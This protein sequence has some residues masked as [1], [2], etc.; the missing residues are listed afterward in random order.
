MRPT[1]VLT[2]L[3]ALLPASSGADPSHASVAGQPS[4][5]Y[6]FALD[7]QP[8]SPEVV[9]VAGRDGELAPGDLIAVNG[10]WLALREPG[11]Y[12]FRSA[13]EGVL[14]EEGDG[15]T[16]WVG[17]RVEP[18]YGEGPDFVDGLAPLTPDQVHGL[19]GLRAETWTRSCA[20][21]AGF[22]DASRVHLALGQSATQGRDD[23][24]ELPP[25][26]RSLEASRFVGWG[27]LRTL[28]SLVHLE[29]LPERTFDVR[30]IAGLR[31]LEVLRV[32]HGR[33]VHAEALA[34]LSAL[35][36]LDLRFHHELATLEFARSL[37]RL[38]E[39]VIDGTGVKDLRPLSELL[40][41]ERVQANGSL[42]ERL[43]AGSLPALREL[44]LVAARAP[45]EEIEAFRRTHP[46][47][48]V[49]HGWN[50]S[51]REALRGATRVRV[52]PGQDLAFRGRTPPTYE[53]ADPAE[54]SGLLRLFEVDE[55]QSG[56]VCGCLCGAT[57]EFLAGDEPLETTRL[58]CNHMLRWRA[59]PGDGAL[60][61]ANA[62]ALRDW[63]ADR[64]V[65]GPR[66]EERES[67]A[68]QEA[69]RRKWARATAG[70]SPGLRQALEQEG[71]LAAEGPN[72]ERQ[73]FRAALAV[74]FPVAADRIRALLRVLGA[75]AGSWSGLDG[76]EVVADRLLR[77]YD[78]R[79]LE[80]VCKA[81]L[82]SGD[83]QLRRGAGRFWD[84]W[85][86]PLESWRPGREPAVR[87]ALLDVLQEGQSPDLRQRALSLLARW[88]AEL[89]A[90]ERDRRLRAGLHDPSE[91]VR[92]QAMLA[93]GRL[94]ATWAEDQLIGVLE[95]QPVR[96][97]PPPPVP[98]EE[99]ETVDL[100]ADVFSRGKS[101]SE[102]ELAG[103]ALGYLRSARARPLIEELAAG[104]GSPMLRV[105][106]ALY[107]GRCD[108]LIADDFRTRDANQALQLAAVESVVRCSGRPGLELA[109]GYRQATQW[110]EEDHVAAVLKAMLLAGHP[111]GASVLK[112]ATSL[113]ELRGWY[114]QFGDE[115]AA[116][117]G[118]QP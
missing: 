28:T 2:V 61:P 95:G 60:V 33:L 97:V 55:G 68:R 3:L 31:R 67:L 52:G 34:N 4:P 101:I 84:G 44:S 94:Q 114:Q 70:W 1:S 62:A 79:E 58:A 113:P 27:S 21:K 88:W 118:S 24:P 82:L 12:R 89:P 40:Q 25:G 32:W 26:L 23:L 20:A 29:I 17:V 83:R 103:L 56:A 48:L 73:R 92:D 43:P 106:R 35:T 65:T 19:W 109:L 30:L 75:E 81:A 15:G 7:G 72:A 78:Q 104:S 87:S 112:A 77:T 74:A 64:G 10:I 91:A 11:E 53:S 96:I 108:L 110:W 42:V 105:A 107:G 50:Q 71:R 38:R 90:D 69:Y 18:N 100:R 41:L 39:V 57:F 8:I 6:R 46:Q 115:L 86:S 59:W 54:I 5:R 37:P 117:D 93:A 98:P 102:G 66:D 36:T 111:P 14:L 16:R 63:L 22:L 47:V 13:L 51:L 9:T 80:A 85:Q 45:S 116:R 99:M 49:R 76:H